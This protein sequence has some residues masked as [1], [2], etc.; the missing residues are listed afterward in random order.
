M[1]YARSSSSRRI[2]RHREAAEKPGVYGSV[3]MNL[4]NCAGIADDYIAFMNRF[5]LQLPGKGGS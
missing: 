1:I 2:I 3:G 5:I 4:N